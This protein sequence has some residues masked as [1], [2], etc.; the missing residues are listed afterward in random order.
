MKKETETFLEVLEECMIK[1]NLSILKSHSEERAKRFDFEKMSLVELFDARFDTFKR[2]SPKD[3]RLIDE[4]IYN[5]IDTITDGKDLL[6]AC[7]Y[8][9]L[10]RWFV[11]YMIERAI[12]LLSSMT[13]K[14]AGKEDWVVTLIKAEA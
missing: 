9:P 2:L 11:D 8:Q 6:T 1:N 10:P 4:V 3:K 5:K 13:A 12:Y 7:G 14:E